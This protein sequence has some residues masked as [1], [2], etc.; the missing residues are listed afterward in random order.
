LLFSPAQIAEF[1]R[2]SVE[3]NHQGLGDQAA[4]YLRKH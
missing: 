2:R 3:L 1:E 4:F